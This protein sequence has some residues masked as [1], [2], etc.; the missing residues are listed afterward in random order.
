MVSNLFNL[1]ICKLTSVLDSGW[2]TIEQFNEAV[3]SKRPD[4]PYQEAVLRYEAEH[5]IPYSKVAL[6]KAELATLQAASKGNIENINDMFSK[7]ISNH[8]AFLEDEECKDMEV[9]A[10][11]LKGKKLT[12]EQLVCGLSKYLKEEQNLPCRS[13]LG[14]EL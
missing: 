2:L 10:E 12:R 3:A 5:G 6:S 11:E 8:V 14:N 7:F 1:L 9:V 13:A 4:E